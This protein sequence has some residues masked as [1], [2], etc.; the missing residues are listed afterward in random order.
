MIRG[1][2]R[3]SAPSQEVVD[4]GQGRDGIINVSARLATT[5]AELTAWIALETFVQINSKCFWGEGGDPDLVLR[6]SA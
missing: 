6:P 1:Y 2:E 4:R 3:A 5:G